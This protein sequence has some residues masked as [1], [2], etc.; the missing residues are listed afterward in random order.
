MKI[1]SWRIEIELEN[2]K[3]WYISDIP[4]DVANMVDEYLTELEAD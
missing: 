4:K 1:V 2:G 3:I